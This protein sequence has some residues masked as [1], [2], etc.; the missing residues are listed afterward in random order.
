MKLR[1][2]HE[3]EANKWFGVDLVTGQPTDNWQKGVI[4]PAVVK[5]NAIKAATEATTL[6]LRIDDLVAAG[7]KSTGDKGKESKSEKSSSEED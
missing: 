7:K 5:M 3:N 2:L 1:S 6:I 4:E